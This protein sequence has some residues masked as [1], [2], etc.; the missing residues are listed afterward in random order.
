MRFLLMVIVV[1]AS[2]A[3]S[4]GADSSVFAGLVDQADRA[5]GRV[6]VKTNE[7]FISG[8]GFVT[9]RTGQPNEFYYV[10]NFHV[11]EDERSTVVI[12]EENGNI[13]D[14]AASVYAT[15]ENYD[16]AVLKI[17]PL[18]DW[19]HE[20][21]YL[22]LAN[23]EI[24]KGE[25]V[26]ALGYPAMADL[27]TSGYDDPAAFQTTFTQGAVSKVTQGAWGGGRSQFE[28]AQHT[29][30]VS[31][32]NSG[33]PL[34]DECGQVVGINTQFTL[35]HL[36]GVTTGASFWAGSS[37]TLIRFLNDYNVSY[38]AGGRRCGSVPTS[39]PPIGRGSTSTITWAI[40]VVTVGGL[41]MAGLVFVTHHIQARRDSSIQMSS[42]SAAVLQPSMPPPDPMPEK[43]P[44]PPSRPTAILTLSL[45]SGEKFNLT[46][47]DLRSGVTIGRG[48][49]NHI[50]IADKSLSRRHARISLQD[51]V[52]RITD[53]GSTN[54]TRIDGERVKPNTGHQITTNTEI[55]LGELALRLMR[56][57]S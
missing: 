32:G 12:F 55:V 23:R 19:D 37:N 44:A 33:G 16:L 8:S 52:L 42:P 20:P 7:S 15:S 21:G 45:G 34:L 2:I 43:P 18:G 47:D 22:E 3:P 1:L 36:D 11:V 53:L 35:E 31:S 26:A 38:G 9:G 39:S 17:H 49:E 29:A 41:L 56:P 28:I 48:T 5:M 4:A 57:A 25:A 50:K 14:Y 13:Y 54:G 6:I 46:K 40:L 10:T 27:T 51:R 30:F 24:R